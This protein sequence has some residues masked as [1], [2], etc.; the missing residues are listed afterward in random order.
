MN[1]GSCQWSHEAVAINTPFTATSQLPDFGCQVIVPLQDSVLRAHS[2]PRNVL[3]ARGPLRPSTVKISRSPIIDVSGESHTHFGDVYN[4]FSTQAGTQ[5]TCYYSAIF[6]ILIGPPW[7][8][9]ISQNLAS[10]KTLPAR[11]CWPSG[12]L[13]VRQSTPNYCTCAA[14]IPRSRSLRFR[15]HGRPPGSRAFRI[16]AR[17]RRYRVRLN[18]AN[19]QWG[20]DPPKEV[21]G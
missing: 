20:K 12:A 21:V 9:L 6:L 10:V 15:A 2:Q 5:L 7:R 17:K 13:R 3:A 18:S 11:P 8:I 14:S 4:K 16:A 19:H 1:V